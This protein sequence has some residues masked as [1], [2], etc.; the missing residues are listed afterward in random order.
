MAFLLLLFSYISADY[1]NAAVCPTALEEKV[2]ATLDNLRLIRTN[3]PAAAQK[4]IEITLHKDDYLRSSLTTKQLTELAQ[5]LSDPA[6]KHH[7]TSDIIDHFIHE[8]LNTT[9]P[10][11]NKKN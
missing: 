8:K 10:L 5:Q 3:V 6:K 11:D 2:V 1:S 4:A 9:A 7:S